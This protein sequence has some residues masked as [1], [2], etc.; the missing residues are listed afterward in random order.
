FVDGVSIPDAASF[1]Q[2]AIKQAGPGRRLPD[3]MTPVIVARDGRPVLASTAIGGGLHQRN[4]Q[5]LAGVLE[6]GL[7]AQAAVGARAFLLPDW[8]NAKG[9]ARVAAGSFDAKVLAGVRSLGQEVKELGPIER[10]MFIGYWAGLAIDPTTGRL[11]G[12]GTAELP[13]HAEGY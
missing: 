7:D 2:D 10:G 9:V 8:E 1:Q 5:V 3:P 6:F 13:S 12:A 11:R 4:I